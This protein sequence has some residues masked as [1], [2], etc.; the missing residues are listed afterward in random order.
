[1]DPTLHDR[2]VELADGRWLVLELAAGHAATRPAASLDSLY[3]DL[4]NRAR[5]RCGPL[6]DHVLELLAA[7]GTGPVLPVAVLEAALHRR[8]RTT[9]AALFAILGDEDLHRVI[10]RTGPGTPRDHAGLFHQTLTDHIAARADLSKAHRALAEALDEL[11]PEHNPKDFRDDPAHAYA[12]DAQASHWWHAERP[13]RVVASLNWRTDIIPSVNL[14][15]W[16]QWSDRLQDVL[17][18]DHPDTLSARQ[19]VA[20][21]TGETGDARG[22][23]TLFQAL[24]PDLERVLGADHPDTLTTEAWINE[25]R[26]LGGDE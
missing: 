2:L 23:L 24:L 13:E 4:I 12:F 21:W 17:G 11:A 6:L 16:Q 14:A 25:L 22:A 7:A 5:T 9:R 8:S 19:N 26:A 18:A 3:E 10:D 20:Y 1:V 15:R